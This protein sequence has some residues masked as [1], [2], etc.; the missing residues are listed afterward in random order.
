MATGG[1]WGGVGGW[2]GIILDWRYIQYD[3]LLLLFSES[4]II[5]NVICYNSCAYTNTYT[6]TYTYIHEAEQKLY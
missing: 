4:T 6:Y 3:L 1:H 2:V 5:M